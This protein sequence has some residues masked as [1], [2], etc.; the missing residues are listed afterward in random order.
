MPRPKA[1]SKLPP[2]VGLSA[3]AS[4]R[5][6]SVNENPHYRPKSAGHDRGL[7]TF[8]D[9]PVCSD[10]VGNDE[11][12][13]L[14]DFC[15][16]WLHLECSGTTQEFFKLMSEGNAGIFWC[17]PT[18][19]SPDLPNCLRL[20]HRLEDRQDKLEQS[21]VE[22]KESVDAIGQSVDKKLLLLKNTIKDDVLQ[23]L[24]EARKREANIIVS[25][26]QPSALS[27]VA[28]VAKLAAD[29]SVHLPADQVLSL[30]RIG[31]EINGKP[32]LL[33]IS[34]NSSQSARLMLG[35]AYKLKDLPHYKD[36]FISPDRMPRQQEEYK[37]LRIELK[38][39]RDAGENV[40]IKGNK[41]VNK[42]NQ[43]RSTV[44]RRDSVSHTASASQLHVSLPPL[45]STSKVNNLSA[46]LTNSQQPDHSSASPID[47]HPPVDGDAD[48]DHFEL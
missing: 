28:L 47:S 2:T 18:C 33:L 43:A 8:T 46:R 45:S 6:N 1:K 23:E 36:V 21:F 17:C 44:A 12:V 15:G 37:V 35:S 19:R 5:N 9:C 16:H 31:K 14:C 41:I 32:K 3:T 13:L 4:Q 27:D 40:V 29:L 39:R 11:E 48:S 7:E 26:L 20:L 34:F 24:E 42:Q 25:G 38:R 22:L 30:R 10:D